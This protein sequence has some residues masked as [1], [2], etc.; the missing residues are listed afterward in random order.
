MNAIEITDFRKE[1]G[2]TVAVRGISLSVREG[3]LF[4]LIGPDGS[5]KT[6]TMRAV[7]TLLVPD[8]GTILVQGLDTSRDVMRIRAV[9]G[10]MPQRFS[11]YQDLSVEQNL[12]FFADL[13]RVPP[14]ERLEREEQ[15]Y[16]FSR[17]S[18]FKKRKAAALSGGM[19][20]KLALSCALVHTPRVLVLDEPTTG[21]D[22]VSRREFWDILRSIQKQGTTI[23][24]STA[25]LDE[26]DR[27]DRVALMYRGRVVVSG[28]P[29]SVREGF[30]YPLYRLKGK[31][32]RALQAQFAA[33]AETR[34]TQLFGDALHVVF[35]VEPSE[36]RWAEW[37]ATS[38]GNL[39]TWGR[40]PPS[41]EDV[42]MDLMS[43]QDEGA[44]GAAP[45]G[46]RS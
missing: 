30:S 9:L 34:T 35:N 13:F 38:A 46:A 22:P 27:C 36:S 19:K 14:A 6:T 23:L 32:V 2:T 25:Y 33:A 3:E 40:Q 16:R 15:L 18:E 20:Q 8:A 28:A 45:A 5:G 41:I 24:V 39:E 4:G 42:F 26:A 44:P 31:D 11:L 37:R 17:L 7:C 21:V 29:S 12:R 10:Y 43:T 1:Y